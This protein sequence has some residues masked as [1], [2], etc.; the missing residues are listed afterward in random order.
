MAEF[1]SIDN[2][3]RVN[4]RCLD[5]LLMEMIST[6]IRST[7][8]K[9]NQET[10]NTDEMNTSNK[11]NENDNI[12]E[13]DDV[14]GSVTILDH[15][16]INSDDVTLRNENYGF[17][18]GIRLCELLMYKNLQS[19]KITNILDIMKFVC[20]DVWRCLYG[21][22]MDNLRTNHR[23]IFV[24]VDNN[25]RL[26]SS[27]NSSKGLPD[28]ISRARSFLWFP[29]GVIRGILLSFGIESLVNAEINNYPSV[30]FSIQTSINN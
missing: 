28:T 8:H 14:P 3:K 24:L 4:A 5:F 27:M 1:D 6:S 11:G 15:P 30:I 23:G 19:S 10:K 7:N 13:L 29:C 17:Q 18:V 22:Q 26:I 16:S 21:K 2:V 25:C 12:D 20:R 9:E